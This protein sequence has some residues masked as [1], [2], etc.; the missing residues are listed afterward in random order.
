[1]AGPEAQWPVLLP[2]RVLHRNGEPG[3]A[4]RGKAVS[5]AGWFRTLSGRRSPSHQTYRRTRRTVGGS[6]EDHRGSES[7]LHDHVG[8]S[9][10]HLIN[11]VM[12]RTTSCGL[13][14]ATAAL[15]LAA[16]APTWKAK[17]VEQW[18]DSDA[19]QV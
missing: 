10:E 6:T 4:S 16:D 13:F 12:I 9:Q 11:L 1:M 19:K 14:L 18:D 7:T 17:P 2:S 3:P 5:I 15:L 8:C